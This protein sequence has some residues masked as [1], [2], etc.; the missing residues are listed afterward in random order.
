MTDSA[1][2]KGQPPIFWISIAVSVVALGIGIAR[3]AV[4]GERGGAFAV[5]IGIAIVITGLILVGFALSIRRRQRDLATAFPSAITVPIAVGSELA[6]SSGSLAEAL[7][8]DRIGM[9]ASS[10]AALAFDAQGVHVASGQAGDFGLIPASRVAA[11]GYGR[12]LLGTREMTSVRL[13]VRTDSGEVDFAFV[14]I[15]LRGNPIRQLTSDEF[16]ALSDQLSRAMSGHVV[17]P[18]WPY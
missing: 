16:G 14:P 15:R 4:S 10:Y 18:G 5:G 1:P 11:A 3:I 6:A 7:G 8:D 17:Q 13:T 2:R 12:S 9:R